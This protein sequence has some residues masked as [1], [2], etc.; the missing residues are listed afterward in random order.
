M[1]CLADAPIKDQGFDTHLWT[2]IPAA[3]ILG[4]SLLDDAFSRAAFTGSTWYAP[5]GFSAF[6]LKY[7]V[8]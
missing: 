8:A 6:I 3:A 4:A 5:N 2:D 1:K 7:R